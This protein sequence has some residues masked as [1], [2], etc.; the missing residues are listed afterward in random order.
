MV[1]LS[2]RLKL[3]ASLVPNGARVCDIGTDHGYLSIDLIKN[4]IAKSVIATDVNEKP[5]SRAKKNIENSGTKGIELRLCDGLEGVSAGEVDTVIIAGMGGEVI[6]GI[7]NRGEDVVKRND[8]ILLLQPTT[9]PEALREY[10]FKNGY[11]ILKEEPIEENE[12]LYSV[13]VCKYS[14]IITEN[15]PYTYFIGKVSPEK[16]DGALYIKKQYKRC[17]KC[18]LALEGITK[19]EESYN[20]Y[21][22]VAKALSSILNSVGE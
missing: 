11:E 13:M 18:A 12:K 19:K 2:K 4:G 20:Y 14:G 16:P 1:T 8:K 6:A 15:A 22:S 5:L 21:S 9:S 10:L 7:I 3:I 17:F